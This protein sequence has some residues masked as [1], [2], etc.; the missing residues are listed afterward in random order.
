MTTESIQNNSE[1]QVWKEELIKL[2][3]EKTIFEISEIRI[4]DAEAFKFFES[5]MSPY[6]TF[7]ETWEMENDSE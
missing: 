3:A 1:Y 4:N 2:V 7:R 5:G 6:Q